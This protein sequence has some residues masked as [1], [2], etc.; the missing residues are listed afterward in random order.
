MLLTALL[1]VP[2]TLP[3]ALL[4]WEWPSASLWPWLIL[5]G[6]LGTAGQ[7]FWTHA[8]RLAEASTLAPFSYLQ[9]PLVAVLAWLV[10]GEDVDRYTV[11]GAAIVVGASLYIARRE[12]KVARQARREALAAKVEPQV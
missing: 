12:A 10:F 9:L 7:Y 4:V 8:L 11:I 3:A 2:L 5:T 1:W 6:A